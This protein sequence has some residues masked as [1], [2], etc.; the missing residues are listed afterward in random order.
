[1]STPNE[2][3]PVP[4]RREKLQIS[5]REEDGMYWAE[6]LEHP[7]LLASGESMDELLEALEEAWAIYFDAEPGTTRIRLLAQPVAA[8]LVPA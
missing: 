2:G 6:V 7:G 1:M 4:A 5:I 8:E 3:T